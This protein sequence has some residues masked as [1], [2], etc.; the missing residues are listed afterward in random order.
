MQN[1][2][3]R[4]PGADL[5]F[6]SRPFIAQ[7]G[8][9][10]GKAIK[11]YR[12]RLTESEAEETILRHNRYVK[13]LRGIGILLPE[14]KIRKVSK[15]RK[16]ALEIIQAPLEFKCHAGEIVENGSAEECSKAKDRD[17]D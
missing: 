2:K 1:P 11:R 16:F 7:E 12:G 17:R 14:T 6:F 15:G 5:G 13:K 4:V 10:R 3:V 8:P 9:D